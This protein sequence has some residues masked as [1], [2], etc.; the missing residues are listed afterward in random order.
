MFRES[1]ANYVQLNFLDRYV[2]AGKQAVTTVDG[3][4]AKLVGD[5][6]YPNVDESRFKPLFSGDSQSR[7]NIKI[8]LYVSAL[9]L[10]RMYRFSDEDFLEFLRCGA[11][12]LQYALHTTSED[13]QPL[14]L[15]SLF[16][17]RQKIRQY[18]E[19]EGVDLVKD[20]FT[21]IS[22]LMAVDMGLLPK[23][24]SDSDDQKDPILVRMDSM[25]IEAHAKVMSRLEIL[26]T[27]VA[28]MLRY[29]VRKEFV[30]II[31]ESLSHYLD[32]D[33]HNKTLYYRV[34]ENERAAIQE[35]R[36]SAV[37][38]EMDILHKAL[39]KN[40]SAEILSGI[41][42]YEVFLRVWDEQT[43]LGEDGVRRPKDK[44]DIAP[45]SVQNPFDTTVTYRQKRGHHHGS[46][47]NVAEVH[48]GHGNGVIIDAEVS[49]NTTSDI[50]MAE[51]FV[52]KQEDD[53][54]A[55]QA[56]VDGGYESERLEALAKKKN[57]EIKATSLTG[58]LPDDIMA[59]FELD[60]DEKTVLKCP[61]GYAPVSNKCNEKQGCIIAVM[62]DNCCSSCVH[63][64]KC[65]ARIS[66]RK[67]KSTVTVRVNSVR[68]AKK[69][70][71][72]DTEEMKAVGRHRNGVEGIM[73]V[74]R[75]KYGLD[76]IPV[77]G[78][79]ASALWVWTSL[80]SYNLV[81]YK[82]YIESQKQPALC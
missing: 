41:P 10:K 5:V 57:I 65:K 19:E 69:V 45:D 28:I 77:F 50:D 27:T 11:L 38:R 67:K 51:R 68:R 81:K 20:E 12:N 34:S 7:P 79:V 3:S 59:D 46:V 49:P 29:L 9:I 48:D 53:G 72:L 42:E 4:R 62:P 8:R 16:R 71:N 76:D 35:D 55:I 60:K 13:T 47:L 54:P 80:L 22:K 2:T 75:R 73:S 58:K 43:V 39:S 17:F 33:D 1:S 32:E 6:V 36:V 30:H 44:G 82:K 56:Q 40:F 25:E 26:Y 14:S 70:R 52:E 24:P 18:N 37:I 61:A 66:K 64:E 23:D 63:R 31:P 78:I 74:M 15:S 21:R